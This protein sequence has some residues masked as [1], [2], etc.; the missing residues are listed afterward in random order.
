MARFG[1]YRNVWWSLA[2]E[3]DFMKEKTDD[4]WKD[5]LETVHKHNVEKH[6]VSIHNG[7][8]LW[9]QTDPRLT[10]AS[11]QNGSAVSDFGRAVLFRDVYE[12]PIVFDEVKY[13]GN[14]E[15]RWGNIIAEEMVHR[16]WQG[17]IAGTYV[18]HGE[19]YKHT[20]DMI[21]WSKGGTLRGQSPPRIAFLK[22]VL[23]DGPSEGLEPIDKW[24]DERTCG[25]KGKFYLVYFGKE[26]PKEWRVELPG[27][28]DEAPM[29]L[30]IDVLDT[31]NMT[32]S[33]YPDP[34]TVKSDGAY[35]LT[36]QPAVTLPLP[37]KP[38]QAI[39][40]KVIPK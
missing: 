4:D 22:K 18:T 29:T 10:H 2:N 13:E 21:W 38:Y 23:E 26:S 39:R 6:L 1:C 32:V 31:W 28:K 15:Q 30:S 36:S 33:K 11:I 25:Q 20:S 7:T 27:K 35:R 5:I 16:F 12:K 24:Q 8:R 14:L 3:F 34:V 40:L 9:N 19:T 17:T 37:G